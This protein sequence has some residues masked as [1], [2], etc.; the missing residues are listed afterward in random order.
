[1]AL[2]DDIVILA[3]NTEDL[4]FL[5]EN[6]INECKKTGEWMMKRLKLFILGEIGNHSLECVEIFKYL[7]V[8][9]NSFN[10]EEV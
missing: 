8:I 5:A 3:E 1:M 4:I 6:F 9:V 7:R 10:L 2:A